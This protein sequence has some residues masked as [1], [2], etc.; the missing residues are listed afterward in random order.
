MQLHGLC[1]VCKVKIVSSSTTDYS[2]ISHLLPQEITST[3]I[4][5]SHLL[6]FSL[7]QPPIGLHVYHEQSTF[8]KLWVI[9]NPPISARE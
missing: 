3:E 7:S 2:G 5:L 8:L 9:V 1:F 6:R 4:F